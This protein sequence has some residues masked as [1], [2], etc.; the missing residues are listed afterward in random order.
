MPKA[1]EFN[2]PAFRGVQAQKGTMYVPD[3]GEVFFFGGSNEKFGDRNFNSAVNYMKDGQLY[4]I[5]P[6]KAYY[7][8]SAGK[9]EQFQTELNQ[10]YGVNGAL[11]GNWS[12]AS[13]GSPSSLAIWKQQFENTVKN[14][15]YLTPEQKQQIIAGGAAKEAAYKSGNGSVPPPYMRETNPFNDYLQSTG[16]KLIGQDGI[17]LKEAGYQAIQKDLASK[18]I[19]VNLSNLA[20][21]N[22]ADVLPRLGFTGNKSPAQGNIQDLAKTYQSRQQ[23]T[24]NIGAQTN[25]Q[26]TGPGAVSMDQAVANGTATNYDSALGADKIAQLQAQDKATQAQAGS[27]PATGNTFSAATVPPTDDPRSRGYVPE[28]KHLYDSNANLQGTADSTNKLFQAYHNRP[29]NAEEL[30][31]WSGKT[32]GQL[33]NTLTKTQIFSGADADKI[34]AQMMA[35]GQTYIRNQAELE[36]LAKAGQVS[37]QALQSVSQQG[38]MMF[39]PIAGQTTQSIPKDTTVSSSIIP[40]VDTTNWTPEDIASYKTVEKMITDATSSGKVINPSIEITADMLQRFNEQAQ[41]ELKPYYDQI[42]NQAQEDLKLSAQRLSQDYSTEERKLSGEFGK[43]LEK[44]QSSFASRG[45]N[46]SSDRTNAEQTLAQQARESLAATQQEK[47]RKM[48]DIGIAGE[49][50]LGSSFFPTIEKLKTGAAPILGR[51]GQYGFSA[52]TQSRDLFSPQGGVYGTQQRD[53]LFAEQS[54]ARELET[55]VRNLRSEYYPNASTFG[56]DEGFIGSQN[57]FA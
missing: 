2:N 6:V 49:R 47:E 28:S 42:R 19:D 20:I 13:V 3:E 48:Q 45:L 38:G 36:Q 32:V 33:E 15:Q 34:R 26:G 16:T 5:D 1:I 23:A 21:Y 18:G 31:Y 17:A 7:N 56:K 4:S 55:G 25:I 30:A 54:R 44:T 10:L 27:A 52:S 11:G 57:F 37:P 41:K 53:Q 51:P 43:A 14:S 40:G 29:A 12:G 50:S 35:N 8:S 39:R 46:M 9:L 24:G 22:G